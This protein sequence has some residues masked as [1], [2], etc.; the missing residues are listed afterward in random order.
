MGE[1]VKIKQIENLAKELAEIPKT[2]NAVNAAQTE[3]VQIKDTIAGLSN[4]YNARETFSNL[5]YKDNTSITL[6][7]TYTVKDSDSVQV[8]FNGVFVSNVNA[9]QGSNTLSFEVP[10]STE[11]SD[12][13]VVCYNY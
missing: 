11:L 6:N 1:F 3:I 9:L 13:I 5:E 10:Y 12:T 8:F 4:T 2:M 7:L